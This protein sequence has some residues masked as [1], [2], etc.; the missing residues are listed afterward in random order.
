MDVKILEKKDNQLRF[1]VEAINIA[2]ANALRRAMIAEVPS[3]AIDEIVIIEN[4][5]AIK[6][7]ILAHRLGLIPLKTDLKSYILRE[8]CDCKSESGCS[9][10]GVTLTLEAESLDSTR[11][12]YSKELKSSDP[13]VVPVKD[14]I[15]ILKLTRGQRIRL[16]AYARLGKGNEHAKWQPVSLCTVKPISK[17]TID[18]K[19]CNACKKCVESCYKHV[20]RTN[21]EKIEIADY[22]KCNSCKQCEESCP[23]DAISVKIS[24]DAFVFNLESVG[25]LLPE[26][27][28]NNAVD[29]LKEKTQE[30]IINVSNLKAE[31]EEYEKINQS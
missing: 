7:E 21:K 31:E 6:D 18:K 10:C 22:E 13:Y 27:I 15:S 28:F 5:S 26:Q 20:L 4:S 19:K 1:V 3:M 23:N 14:E 9:R 17:I 24:N 2:V 16:E 25:S 29:I 11:T 8:K 30:F 12:V